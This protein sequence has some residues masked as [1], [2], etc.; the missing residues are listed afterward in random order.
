MEAL[1]IANAGA[2]VMHARS[3]KLADKNKMPLYITS[4]TAP[5]GDSGTHVFERDSCRSAVPIYE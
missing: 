2:K 4:F 3:I 1:N 5:D